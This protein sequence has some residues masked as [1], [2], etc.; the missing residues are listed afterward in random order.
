[1]MDSYGFHMNSGRMMDSYGFPPVWPVPSLPQV[2][3]QRNGVKRGDERGR[4][5]SHGT[6]RGE[7]GEGWR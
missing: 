1:M 7:D 6:W 5:E 4:I 2:G 3:D